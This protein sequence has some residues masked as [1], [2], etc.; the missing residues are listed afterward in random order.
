MLAGFVEPGETVEEAIAR[1]VR[2]ESGIE[3][4][5]TSYVGSQ[6]WPFPH[7]LML[8]FNTEYAGG[9]LKI[10]HSEIED[11]G[12]YALDRLPQLPSINSIAGYMIDQIIK[13]KTVTT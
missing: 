5:N 6:P 13:N 12:W 3:V 4:Q 10:D 9:S 7:S 2:E 8:G 11:A 1:E